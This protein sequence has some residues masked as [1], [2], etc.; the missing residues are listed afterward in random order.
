MELSDSIGWCRAAKP[1]RRRRG[2][3]LIWLLVSFICLVGF[4]SLAV[5]MGR[6]YVVKAQLSQATDAAALYAATGLSSSGTSLARA[7]AIAAAGDNT[8]DGTP[9]TLNS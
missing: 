4:C 7:N 2:S 9:V 8:A 3:I 6:V 5:D 1:G